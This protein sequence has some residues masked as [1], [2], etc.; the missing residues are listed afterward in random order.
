MQF[1]ECEGKNYAKEFLERFFNEDI[2]HIYGSVR[3]DQIDQIISDYAKVNVYKP[4]NSITTDYEDQIYHATRAWILAKDA[5]KKIQ[6]IGENKQ[7]ELIDHPRIKKALDLIR[8]AKKIFILGFGFDEM[9][10]ELLRL[11]AL[12]T[13]N[14]D[15]FYTNFNKQKKLKFLVDELFQ[16]RAKESEDTVFNAFENDFYL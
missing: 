10:V 13:S 14:K 6:V 11:K 12:D 4:R 8:D 2:V 5:A 16:G 15:I 7:L 9:N 1:F 3:T